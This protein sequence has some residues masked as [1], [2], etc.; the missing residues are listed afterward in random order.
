MNSVNFGL[1]L[2]EQIDDPP[3]VVDQRYSI[4]SLAPGRCD[5]NVKLVIFK[6]LS[7]ID[8]LS[9]SCDL[10]DDYSKLVHVND[11]SQCW[12]RFISP[13]GVTRPQWVKIDSGLRVSKSREY[14]Y[15]IWQYKV[16]S[17]KSYLRVKS[18]ERK[19]TRCCGLVLVSRGYRS[20]GHE[21]W[22][23]RA[24]VWNPQPPSLYSH[25][26]MCGCLS[27]HLAI[28]SLHPY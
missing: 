8:I 10:T 6:P 19:T 17:I 9:I 4:N 21:I 14:I 28:H 1:Q 25:S 16:L 12:P 5:C 7:R 13:C 15:G 20:L 23:L 26:I 3:S 24:S 2:E 11:L 22:V 27:I 18:Y